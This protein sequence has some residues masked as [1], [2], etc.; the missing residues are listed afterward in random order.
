MPP[1]KVVA[2][3]S[4]YQDLTVTVEYSK[5]SRA[6]VDALLKGRLVV[7]VR[8]EVRAKVLFGLLE[9]SAP[10]TSTYSVG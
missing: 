9:V 1:T 10:F 5:V 4:V 3:S 2:R 7:E 8:G 6:L